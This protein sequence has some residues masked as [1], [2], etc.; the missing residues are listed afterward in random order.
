MS[1]PP[2]AAP[3]KLL[4]DCFEWCI[5][6]S[7]SG[8]GPGQPVST[9]L[10]ALNMELGISNDASLIWAMEQLQAAGWLEYS[11]RTNGG[12]KLRV[13]REGWNEYARRYRE[14]E[15]NRL[16]MALEFEQPSLQPLIDSVC[17]PAALSMGLTLVT[18]LDVA[19]AGLIDDIMRVAIRRA[20]A[21]LVEL[22]HG[23]RGAYWEGGFA[24]ALDK[25][26]IYLC[27]R[28]EWESEKTHFDTE[29][30]H[31]IVWD[32]NDLDAAMLKLS[33]SLANSLRN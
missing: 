25:P 13:T 9:D 6:R 12:M 30:L 4:N 22:T 11:P 16:F 27:R 31:T 21:V 28:T 26:T 23:N 3:L 8:L 33:A 15:P 14:G 7:A 32:E 29:H 20:R 2:H 5:R 19:R 1:P 24:E 17:K 18:A 10:T